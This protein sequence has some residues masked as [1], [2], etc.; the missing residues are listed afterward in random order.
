MSLLLALSVISESNCLFSPAI[1]NPNLAKDTKRGRANIVY[2]RNVVLDFENGDLLPEELAVDIFPGLRMV[3][4]NTFNH[5]P[6][7][8]RYRAIIPTTENMTADGS[9][10]IYECLVETL[11]DAGCSVRKRDKRTNGS[12]NRPSGLDW[13]T[14]SPHSLF[15]LPCQAQNPENSFF[16]DYAGPSRSPIN[17]STW[18]ETIRVPLQ[19]EW[20][21]APVSERSQGSVNEVLVQDAVKTWRS[22]A[23]HPGRGLGI[24]AKRSEGVRPYLA[25]SRSFASI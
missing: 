15:Y 5:T 25:S 20:E 7:R 9:C 12:N 6:D 16:I 11:E 24:C 13:S 4:T 23:A 21:T 18:L 3:V 19:P 1:F 17:P 10:L 22:S 2:L 14:T 8:P